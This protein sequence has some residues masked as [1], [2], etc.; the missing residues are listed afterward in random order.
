MKMSRL[1]IVACIAVL[2]F[3]ACE[4]GNLRG[5]FNSS[6]DGKTYLAVVDD[7]GGHCGPIRVDGKGWPY[8]I[9]QVGPINPGRHRISCGGEIDFDIPPG[10]VLKFDYWGP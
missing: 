4:K 10:V 9:G 1:A 5:T 3:A 7:G 6:K 8:Q 2:G